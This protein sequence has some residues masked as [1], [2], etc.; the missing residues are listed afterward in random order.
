M[1]DNALWSSDH[2]IISEKSNSLYKISWAPDH[3][4]LLSKTIILT[5]KHEHLADSQMFS[6]L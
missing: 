3:E 6:R 1:L 2:I 4:N 5:R